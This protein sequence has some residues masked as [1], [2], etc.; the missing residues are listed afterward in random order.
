MNTMKKIT[1]LMLCIVLLLSFSA[2]GNVENE[3][4]HTTV[5]ADFQN[6]EE[7]KIPV[8]TEEVTEEKIAE[9]ENLKP[10]NSQVGLVVDSWLKIISVGE[11][12]GK[13]SILVRNISDTDVQFARLSVICNNEKYLFEMSTITA[14]STAVI[15][16]LSEVPFN[17]NGQY[18]SW[19]VEDKIL[20][21]DELSVYPDVFEIKGADGVISVKNISKKKIDGPIYVYYKSVIDGVYT[22][23]TTYR[24]SI[25]GLKKGEEI[26]VLSS[27]YKK[28]TSLVMFVTYAE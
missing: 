23:G 2:C 5:D 10:Q 19:K 4:E 17:A 14:G 16:C 12:K 13:L 18:H 7:I 26:Q 25:D 20:F 28:D 24:I 8:I 11:S 9:Y 22:E 27:H 15:S 3:K 6:V 21:D 1:S